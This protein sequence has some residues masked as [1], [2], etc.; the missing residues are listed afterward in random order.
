MMLTMVK[1]ERKKEVVLEILSSKKTYSQ[2]ALVKLSRIHY[3]ILN[4]ILAELEKEKKIE[5][6]TNRLG[7]F[8]YWRLKK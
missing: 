4:D 8:I 1:H 3:Y 7:T 2:S 6:L 5:R